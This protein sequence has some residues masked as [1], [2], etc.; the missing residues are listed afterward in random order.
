MRKIFIILLF[1]ALACVSLGGYAQTGDRSDWNV[2]PPVPPGSI[3]KGAVPGKGGKTTITPATTN[4]TQPGLPKLGAAK[5]ANLPP[6]SLI[7]PVVITPGQPAFPLMPFDVPAIPL[8]DVPDAIDLPKQAPVDEVTTDEAAFPEPTAP[9]MPAMPA[10]PLTNTDK[11]TV[12]PFKVP[13]TPPLVTQLSPGALS[14]SLFP[15]AD[16]QVPPI[17]SNI[18]FVLVLPE[19]KGDIKAKPKILKG[20]QK[21]QKPGN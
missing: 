8:P 10:A 14:A 19:E 7:L 11:N 9:E 5:L 18:H 6:V 12:A 16:W 1:T 2:P 21:I 20:R 15:F 17:L 4:V 13:L 3:P